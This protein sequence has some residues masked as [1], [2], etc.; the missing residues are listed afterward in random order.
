MKKLW[1][2]R[3][4]ASADS[5]A[6][7]FGASIHFDK[8][9]APFDIQGSIAHATMLGSTGIISAAEA[10]QIVSGLARVR[11]R[12]ERS[13]IEFRVSDEDIHMNIERY[14]T[15]EIGPV[16]GK[17][18][19]A[20]SRN[21]QVATD[22]H[23]FM[24]NAVIESVEALRELQQ[25]LLEQAEKGRGV[26][27]PGYTHLQR[28]QPVYFSHHL[29]AY[30]QMFERDINRA[31]DLWRRTNILP[32]GAGAI[33]G[34]TFPIDRDQVASLL[35]FDGVY[36]NS[37]DA[38]SDRDFVLEYLSLASICMMHLSRLCEEIIIWTTGEFGYIELDDSLSTG[39]SMMP[40]KKN[41]DFAELVRGK[42]GRVYGSLM[43]LLTTMKGLPLTYNKDMQ[44][45]KEGAFDAVDTVLG[46]LTVVTAMVRT[47]RVRPD[48]MRSS[49]EGGFTNATDAADYLAKKGLPFRDA[50]EVVGKLVRYC[51]E[52]KRALLDLSL[53]EF[54]GYSPLF[55]PD[56]F[57]ALKL[58]N[59]VDRRNS[60]GGTGSNSITRQIDI[61][62]GFVKASG[63][64]LSERR[65]SL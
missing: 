29:L 25:G 32:L 9:L 18:H 52:G 4:A 2:G 7:E 39:S 22:F 65:K 27:M 13:E 55:E 24:R 60:R 58:E 54:K 30:A 63:D 34:T 62:R 23:L 17:L 11:E 6:E 47:W 50:H 19:T 26:I 35:H 49:A 42:T 57:T 37:M 36:E 43:G 15:E 53:D 51:V 16:A 41:A 10:Q 31:Q 45:D 20:R 59:V 8:R 61:V 1:G 46:S 3:F 48:V 64:W 14:L 56:V 21:D 33:A 28:A 38:V 44:E 40:Q 5:F 12:L